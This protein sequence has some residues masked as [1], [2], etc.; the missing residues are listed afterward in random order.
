M[1]SSPGAIN[2]AAAPGPRVERAY[3][4][5]T[6]SKRTRRNFAVGMAFISPWTI[7]FLIFTL[8]P[9]VASLVYSFSEYTF[10]QPL[11]WVGL[12]NYLALLRDRYFWIALA[13]TAYMV[14]LGVPLML[15]FSLLC[16]VVLN[17]KTP[18]QSIYRLI[19]YIPSIVPTIAAT[20]LWV[21]ILNP[22]YGLL[23]TLLGALGIQGP[24]WLRDPLWSKPSLLLMALWSAGN[25]M[26]IYLSGL[27]DVPTQILEAADLDGATCWPRMRHITLP[28]VS[29]ITLYNLITLSIFMFQYFAQAYVFAHVSGQ[30]AEG[31]SAIGQPLNSTLFYSLYLYQNAFQFLKMGYASAMAW[32]LF[33]VILAFTL[34]LLRVFDRFGY[35]SE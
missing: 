25:V 12:A 30:N 16:A 4:P 24:N 1:P 5:F 23:N 7:G 19:Y 9:M 3:N 32:I 10:R 22:Q 2:R 11:E 28:M 20:L 21:W 18:G 29:P 17:I 15:T 6:W 33:L 13:N 31:A 34:V 35:N 27:Q 14:L 8:Y 26:I